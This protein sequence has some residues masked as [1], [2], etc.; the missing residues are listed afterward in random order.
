MQ[1]DINNPRKRQRL[2]TNNY[3]EEYDENDGFQKE[4]F[5]RYMKI[6]KPSAFKLD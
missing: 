6:S 3:R 2:I 5:D 1:D 4:M